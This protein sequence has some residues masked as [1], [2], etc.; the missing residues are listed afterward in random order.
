LYFS[1]IYIF[2][3]AIPNQQRNPD[4]ILSFVEPRVVNWY[5]VTKG[6]NE[7]EKRLN[8]TYII[9][10]ARKLGCSIFLLPKDIVEVNPKM[11]LILIGCIMLWSLTQQTSEDAGISDSENGSVTISL[12]KKIIDDNTS[13]ACLPLDNGSGRLCGSIGFR[14][15]ASEPIHPA[16]LQTLK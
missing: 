10:V 2:A 14:S 9:N 4:N 13:E 1:C 7:E 15:L 11:I 16:E 3:S 8:A 5:I 12:S 6:K